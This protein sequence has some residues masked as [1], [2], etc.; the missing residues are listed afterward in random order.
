VTSKAEK[1]NLLVAS[2][3]EPEYIDKIRQVDD[4]LNVIYEPSLLPA[5][6]FVG[7]HTGAPFTRTPEQ[8]KQWLDLLAN[9]DIMLD[10]DKT[11]KKELPEVA[12]RVRWI[13]S[14]STGIGQFVHDLEYD[15]LMP[16]TVFTIAGIHGRPLAEF[17][18]M[19]LLMH[20]KL[21]DLMARQKQE[22]CFDRYAGTDA[23]GRTMA[24]LGLGRNGT[25]VAKLARGIGMRVL[26]MDLISKPEV[27]DRFYKREAL[28]DML[29]GAE[30][31]VVAMPDTPLTKNMIGANELALLKKGA[32][33]VN[34]SRGSIVDETA[35]IA[36]LNSGQLSGAALDVFQQE[37]L[38]KDSPFWEMPNVMISPHAASISDREN[39]RIIEVFCDNLRRYL[40]GKSLCNVLNSEL[41]Y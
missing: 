26:G 37:P 36:A 41:L 5:P 18:I 19:A 10:F 33:L 27:V 35:M 23:D 25:M 6:R 8:E 2:Y 4:R 38:P 29:T 7:D 9:A 11:H 31:L 39:G 3:I 1:L 21:A 30:V 14:T 15:K 13:Q 12:R 20:Y 32:Y 16:N 17:T 34:I 40:D 28:N 22:K 24:I